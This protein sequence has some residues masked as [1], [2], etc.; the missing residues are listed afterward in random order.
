MLYDCSIQSY[1]PFAEFCGLIFCRNWCSGLSSWKCCL[2][3]IL[4]KSH[5][6][7]A[8]KLHLQRCQKKYVFFNQTISDKYS[9][10]SPREIYPSVVIHSPLI[11]PP[12]KI[13]VSDI[14]PQMQWSLD[15]NKL[16]SSKSFVWPSLVS[17][18]FFEFWSLEMEKLIPFFPLQVDIKPLG[19]RLGTEKQRQEPGGFHLLHLVKVGLCENQGSW[20]QIFEFSRLLV[21]HINAF[22]HWIEHHTS[23]ECYKQ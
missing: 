19:S 15:S 8:T 23:V 16:Y 2:S 18:C 5:S 3:G 21:V 17:S 6:P 1:L 9:V 22:R 12:A 11:R 13:E 20:P 10:L 14:R 4:S 7:I